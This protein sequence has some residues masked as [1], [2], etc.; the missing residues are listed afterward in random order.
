VE[1][2]KESLAVRFRRAPSKEIH[3]VMLGLDRKS[4]SGL[5]EKHLSRQEPWLDDAERKALIFVSD[6][7]SANPLKEI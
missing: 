6:H 2:G 5:Q 3:N 4:A 7:Y 1:R